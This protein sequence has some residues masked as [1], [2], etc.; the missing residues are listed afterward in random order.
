MDSQHGPTRARTQH[1][2]LPLAFLTG[3]ISRIC[4]P[5]RNAVLRGGRVPAY[6]TP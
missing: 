6:S 1:Q 2:A 5:L 4:G 3:H